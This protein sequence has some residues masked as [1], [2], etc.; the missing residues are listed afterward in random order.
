MSAANKVS[1]LALSIIHYLE[2]HP[3][4]TVP[5]C[6]CGES[7]TIL[8]SG[9]EHIIPNDIEFKWSHVSMLID[10][11]IVFVSICNSHDQLIHK[12]WEKS[13]CNGDI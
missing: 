3:N 4:I 7:E 12:S 9:N 10:E 11:K 2:Y 8:V 13:L 6:F 1:K 5:V